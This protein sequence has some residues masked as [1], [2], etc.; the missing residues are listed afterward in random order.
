MRQ[1]RGRCLFVLRFSIFLFLYLNFFLGRLPLKLL[2]GVPLEFLSE[3][4]VVVFFWSHNNSRA[5]LSFRV[6]AE[7]ERQCLH[8]LGTCLRYR[9]YKHSLWGSSEYNLAFPQDLKSLLEL[10]DMVKK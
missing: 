2:R 3:S 6:L 7:K 8:S 9:Q 4:E 10:S 1:R 5:S